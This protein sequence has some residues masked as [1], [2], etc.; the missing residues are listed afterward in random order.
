MKQNMLGLEVE[1]T[2]DKDEWRKRHF[3]EAS[4]PVQAW[5]KRT[6]NVDDD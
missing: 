6:I 4:E 2:K 1:D 3:G 5:T